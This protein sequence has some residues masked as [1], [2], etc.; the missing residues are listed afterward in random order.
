MYTI[1]REAIANEIERL[2]C[3]LGIELP[4]HE[5]IEPWQTLRTEKIRGNDEFRL[6]AILFLILLE[7]LH[8]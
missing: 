4:D 3:F 2:C 6:Y 1:V 7:W 5:R 8:V